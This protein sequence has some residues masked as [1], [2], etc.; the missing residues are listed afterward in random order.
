MNTLAQK[1]FKYESKAQPGLF[2]W[3]EYDL[4]VKCWIVLSQAKGFP[5]TEAWD[6]WFGRESDADKV[7]RM[8]ANGETP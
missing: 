7:A 6:D 2:Y 5:E 1:T 3:A 8:L 4:L